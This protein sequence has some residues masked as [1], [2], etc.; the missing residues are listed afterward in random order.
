M[1]KT[2]LD[3]SLSPG[4]AFGVQLRRLREAL[5]LTQRELGVLIGFSNAWVS[6][7]ERAT[8]IPTYDFAVRCDTALATGGTLELMWWGLKHSSFIEGFAE[9]A[10]LAAKAIA[11]R[12][13]ELS[14][15]PGLLQTEEYAAVLAAAE[16]KRGNISEEQAS[17]RVSFLMAR[18]KQ[19]LDRTPALVFHA[20]LDE[21]CLRCGVGGP[22]VMAR[23]FD[24]LEAIASR[25]GITL[26]IAPSSLGAAR[27]F[28][29]PVTILTM[30]DRS[31]VGYT[32]TVKR[33]F[34]ERDSTT[35]AAWLRGYD[36]L[37]IESLS[38]SASLS[39]IR[40]V[41]KELQWTDNSL[42]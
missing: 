7:I 3:P 22:A 15:I 40:A 2:T 32:E 6:C 30:P 39:P 38:Q 29:L 23:Q 20:V 8:R 9:Y 12:L 24:H 17:E 36:Q 18:Q 26:Q 33:G 41:R 42:T 14:V 10:V 34:L 11:I 28:V 25:P 19:L 21:S 31:L 16:V 5:G 35:V 13:F 1:R 4:A 37:Q 27:P